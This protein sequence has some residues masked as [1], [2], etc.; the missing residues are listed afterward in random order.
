MSTNALPKLTG[1]WA[2]DPSASTVAFTIKHFGV[3]TVRGR[4]T[5]FE[6]TLD[7]GDDLSSATAAGRLNVA[8][9]DT[10]DAKRDDGLRAEILEVDKYPEMTLESVAFSPIVGDRFEITVDLTIHGVTKR[11]ALSAAIKEQSDE[12]LRLSLTGQLHR[13]DFAL[14]F[15]VTSNALVS[16]KLALTLEVTATRQGG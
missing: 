9:L 10:G 2:V 3:A 8:T 1:T 16:D 13:S 12:R 11:A 4:F 15:P 5:G 14:K 6:G 7:I